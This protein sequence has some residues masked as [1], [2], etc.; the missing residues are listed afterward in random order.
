MTKLLRTIGT[1][2]WFRLETRA[3]WLICK[4]KKK[5]NINPKLIKNIFI[6]NGGGLWDLSSPGGGS[7]CCGNIEAGIPPGKTGN[8]EGTG[9]LCPNMADRTLGWLAKEVVGGLGSSGWAEREAGGRDIE[10][11]LN[12]CSVKELLW[13]ILLVRKGSVGTRGMG[14]EVG[15]K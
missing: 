13:W 2:E 14:N 6:L 15:I 4:I 10:A 12:N 11:S 5:F 1:P 7:G 3:I 8:T 9:A